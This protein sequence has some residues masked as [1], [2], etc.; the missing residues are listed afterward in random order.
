MASCDSGEP[1]ATRWPLGAS[2][3]RRV[4]GDAVASWR[5]G[6]WEVTRCGLSRRRPGA[7]VVRRT[8]SGRVGV[9]DT[10]E[11][12]KTTLRAVEKRSPLISW[13]LRFHIAAISKESTEEQLALLASWGRGE[14][15]RRTG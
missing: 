10:S 7:N 8:R 5:G 15:M 3:G 11:R 6:E 4:G 1:E 14:S 13:V 12:L 9:W 2:T